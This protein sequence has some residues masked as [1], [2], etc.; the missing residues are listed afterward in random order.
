VGDPSSQRHCGKDLPLNFEELLQDMLTETGAELE[1]S[2]AD[3][4]GLIA[5]QGASLS[6]AYNE[7]G[8]DRVLRASRD[9]LAIQLGIKASAAS[10]LA[11]GQVLGFIQTMLMSAAMG[12][13]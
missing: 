7:P 5:A 6:L 1:M 12:A 8:F 10:R 11:E 9:I 4:V 2:A 3:A 13:L